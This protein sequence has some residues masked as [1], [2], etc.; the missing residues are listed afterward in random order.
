M[1]RFKFCFECELN[2]DDVCQAG[3]DQYYCP[4][5]VVDF[6]GGGC[7]ENCCYSEMDIRM[8]ENQRVCNFEFRF[9]EC[10]NGVENP[11]SNDVKKLYRNNLKF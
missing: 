2:V 8:K 6:I 4:C 7:C 1:K 5:P 10:P 3:G 11:L 9:Y